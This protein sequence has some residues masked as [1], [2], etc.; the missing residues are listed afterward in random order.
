MENK[1][2]KEYFNEIYQQTIR[3]LHNEE[4]FKEAYRRT[5]RQLQIDIVR[6]NNL[7]E[8]ALEQLIACEW[9]VS[10]G[11]ISEIEGELGKRKMVDWE[12][13][14]NAY[15]RDNK[16]DF[17]TRKEFLEAL[18]AKYQVILKIERVIFINHATIVHAMIAEGI[19]RLPKGNRWPSSAMKKI[20]KLDTKT[21]TCKEIAKAA[22]IQCSHC[23]RLLHRAELPFKGLKS[24]KEE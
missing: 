3:Q 14:I 5:I 13:T 8:Q 12:A 15:N 19:P 9:E 2:D 21:M 18:Y 6:K 24:I 20:Y 23:Y 17:K 4:Y 10:L 11:T 22:E 1:K 7:L 16:T